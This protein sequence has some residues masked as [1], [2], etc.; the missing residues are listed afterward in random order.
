MRR[1][2]IAALILVTPLGA[3]AQGYLSEPSLIGPAWAL[4]MSETHRPDLSRVA[5]GERAIEIE[6]RSSLGGARFDAWQVRRSDGVLG[7]GKGD[8]VGGPTPVMPSASVADP[9]GAFFPARDV[10]IEALPQMVAAALESVKFATPAK[11]ERISLER[12]ATILPK[13]GH[14]EPRWSI[15]LGNGRETATVSLMLD[16]RPLGADISQ[17]ERGRTRDFLVQSD[18]PFEQAQAGFANLVGSGE[19]VR[20][21]TVRSDS[22]GVTAASPDFPDQLTDWSWDGGRFTRGLLDM[23]DVSVH[24]SNPD[25]PFALSELDL[26]ELPQVLAAARAAAEEDGVDIVSVEAAK[27]PMVGAAPVVEWLVTLAGAR[28]LIGADMEDDWEVRVSTAG[29]VLSVLPPERLRKQ[30]SYLDGEAFAASVQAYMDQIGGE[31]PVLELMAR[32]ESVDVTGFDAGDMGM[33][34]TITYDQTGFEVRNPFPVMMQTEADLFRLKALSALTAGTV[35]AMKAKAV[36]EV[37]MEGAEV[38]S[39]RVWSG[40]PFWSDPQG[41][42]FVDIRVGIPPRHDRGGYVVFLADGSFVETVK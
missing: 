27:K 30:A 25:L 40:A 31:S 42:Q 34:L 39:L 24:L 35:E 14:G 29:V 37:A 17:T 36:E 21:V 16:G 11:V 19:T 20:A 15:T 7:L 41:R 5:I 18:W 8:R 6:A 1:L 4:L 23:P 13:A 38:Y 2:L 12:Q 10:Q 26:S 32:P 9:A 22:I 33:T 3:R 28:P